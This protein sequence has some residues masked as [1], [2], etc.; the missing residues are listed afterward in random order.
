MFEGGSCP[1]DI[2]ANNFVS[3]I[4]NVVSDFAILILPQWVI[5]NLHT[6]RKKRTEASLLFVIGLL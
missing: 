4:I 5:W 6:T 3:G 2:G 1:V